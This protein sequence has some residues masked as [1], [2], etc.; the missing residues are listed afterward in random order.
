M[1]QTNLSYRLGIVAICLL[2]FALRLHLLEDTFWHDD[3]V[4]SQ[5]LYVEQSP[6]QILT[7]YTANNHWLTSGL[8]H[9]MG[10]LG[11]QRFLLRWPA[12]LLGVLAVPLI[13]VA[14]RRL[15]KQRREGVVAACLLSFSAFHVQWSQQFRGYTALLFFGLLAFLLLYRALQQGSRTAWLSFLAGV[16]LTI[17]SHLFG[18]LM[19]ITLLAI[20]AGWTGANFIRR[21]LEKAQLKWRST[22]FLITLFVVVYFTWFAKVNI[23]DYYHVVPDVS[24]FQ[25]ILYQLRAAAPT[26]AEINKLLQEVAIAFTAQRDPFFASSLFWVPVMLGVGLSWRRFPR[27]ALLLATWLG[28][29]LLLVIWAEFAV[30]GFF[31]SDRYLIFILPAWLLLASHSLVAGASELA[32]RLSQ[33]SR[34]RALLALIL[35]IFMLGYLGR[36]NLQ[37]IRLYFADR[38]GQ[39]WRQIALFLSREGQLSPGDLII[40]KQL[41]HTWPFPPL[42]I[43]ERCAKE[44]GYRLGEQLRFPVVSLEATTSLNTWFRFKG[45]SQ[46]PGRVWLIAWGER[47]AWQSAP[48]PLLSAL[49]PLERRP[50]APALQPLLFNRLGETILLKVDTEPQLA[51]NLGEAIGYLA[52]L[53]RTSQ[54]QFDY[55]LRQAQVLAYQGRILEAEMALNIARELVPERP[56]AQDHLAR[57]AQVITFNFLQE[58]SPPTQPL[59]VEFGRPPLLR[60]TGYQLSH[61]SRAGQ[62]DIVTTSWEALKPVPTDYTVFLHLRDPAG[63]TVAQLDFRPFEGAYPTSQWQPGLIIT[64]SR[65]WQLPPDLPAGSYTLHLGLYHLESLAHLA[66]VKPGP[67]PAVLLG[68]IK[69]Q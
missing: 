34:S 19:V 51:G 7:H 50:G 49:V 3:E 30:A 58:V 9:L 62:A 66:P 42:D 54:D 16:F 64:E 37:I 36:L 11:T 45:Q 33:T 65:P 40:C 14:G 32:A 12:L 31:V 59:Q 2:A 6:L 57:T 17:A 21:H 5:R 47:E 56:A 55:Y 60:L 61:S 52:R 10:Y 13:G 1:T 63:Q 46:G 24:L 53:D 43:E 26:L 69:V 23:I 18:V 15:F 28:L 27:S 38:A 29:P 67:G 20:L 41:P 39:D 44:L 68:E 48:A 22:V 25:L 8:G 35:V 4:K